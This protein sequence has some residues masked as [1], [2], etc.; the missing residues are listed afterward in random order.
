MTFPQIA[1]TDLMQ[2]LGPWIERRGLGGKNI[3]NF[4]IQKFG[5]RF[6]IVCFAGLIQGLFSEIFGTHQINVLSFVDLVT[7]STKS[8][9]QSSNRSCNLTGCT[10]F[11]GGLLF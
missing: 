8:I 10:G 3:K 11:L 2:N 9:P 7:F 6:S 5:K 4:L 1:S